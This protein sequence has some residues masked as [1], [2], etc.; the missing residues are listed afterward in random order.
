[1]LIYQRIYAYIANIISRHQWRP[2]H[3]G[4]DLQ[5]MSPSAMRGI[6]VGPGHPRAIS[7]PFSSTPSFVPK[8]ATFGRCWKGLPTLARWWWKCSSDI[9]DYVRAELNQRREGGREGERERAV[10][11]TGRIIRVCLDWFRNMQ[12]TMVCLFFSFCHHFPSHQIKRGCP[13]DPPFINQAFVNLWHTDF[14][15]TCCS[16]L[17]LAWVRYCCPRPLHR[18]VSVVGFAFIWH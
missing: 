1:M 8:L 12:E 11:R 2:V 7:I 9:T 10:G 16:H 3:F 4:W 13:V 15:L 14:G 17:D 6:G 18:Q 5:A